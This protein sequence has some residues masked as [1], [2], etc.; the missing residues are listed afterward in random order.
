M[1]ESLLRFLSLRCFVSLSRTRGLLGFADLRRPFVG[2]V[3]SLNCRK[4]ITSR[5]SAQG[6]FEKKLN[7]FSW[8]VI[9][10]SWFVVRGPW[11]VVRARAR[12][13][14][15]MAL[16][17]SC[18]W[19]AH[20]G[21]HCGTA[22]ARD[23]GDPVA[24]QWRGARCGKPSWPCGKGEGALA[25]SREGRAPARPP[26]REVPVGKWGRDGGDPRAAATRKMRVVPG[27]AAKMA[28]PPS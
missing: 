20:G 2:L 14:G 5:G 16:P 28:A 22:C 23:E 7:F 15:P 24:C 26:A 21:A 6:G 4:C 8:L 11:S 9:R 13:R 27:R 19:C 17:I 1:S 18:L 12:A 25:T 3:W 10:D